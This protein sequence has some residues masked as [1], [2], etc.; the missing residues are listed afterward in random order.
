MILGRRRGKCSAEEHLLARLAADTRHPEKE[1]LGV[2][3]F[4]LF[5]LGDW[6]ACVSDHERRFLLCGAGEQK[7]ALVC[8][9]IQARWVLGL[10]HEPGKRRTVL[11]GDSQLV[12]L[13][14]DLKRKQ[15]LGV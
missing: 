9:G 6:D 15:H 13:L 14:L 12:V 10:L 5:V 1:S 8:P 11:V 3:G 7:L 2:G 4:G